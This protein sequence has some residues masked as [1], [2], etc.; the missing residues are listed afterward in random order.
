MLQALVVLMYEG[1]TNSPIDHKTYAADN[2]RE[3]VVEETLDLV[4][5]T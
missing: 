2:F 3:E 5:P 1:R 4:A